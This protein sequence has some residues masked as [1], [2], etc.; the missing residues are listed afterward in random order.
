MDR[1]ILHCDANLFMIPAS[2]CIV[3]PCVAFPSLPV[4]AQRSVTRHSVGG[5]EGS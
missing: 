1:V 2:L 5:H 4:A 3:Q